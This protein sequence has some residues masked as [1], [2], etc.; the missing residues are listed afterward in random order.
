MKWCKS[1]FDYSLDSYLDRVRLRLRLDGIGIGGV[2][3]RILCIFRSEWFISQ[4]SIVGKFL[5][6][7]TKKITTIEIHFPDG[8]FDGINWF[9]KKKWSR[10]KKWFTKRN[11]NKKLPIF[12]NV[13]TLIESSCHCSNW[14]ITKTLRLHSDFIAGI[15]L[16]HLK[17]AEISIDWTGAA[18]K[19]WVFDEQNRKKFCSI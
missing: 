18:I 11:G 1:Y 17:F 2:R 12:F 10:T 7:E 13:S 9:K 14:I 6:L 19:C 4:Y 8:L 3:G 5:A 16:A 15:L